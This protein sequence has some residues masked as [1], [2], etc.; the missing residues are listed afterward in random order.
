[1]IGHSRVYTHLVIA[2]VVAITATNAVVRTVRTTDRFSSLGELERIVP[3]R[4]RD[5]KFVSS[6]TCQACHPEHY[7]SWHKTFHRT[8]TQVASSQ[9]VSGDFRDVQ[10]EYHEKRFRLQQRGEE[11]WVIE[12]SEERRVFMTT[13][14]HHYQVYW[15]RSRDGDWL[16][17]FP[18]VY[19]LDDRRW[20]PRNDAFMMPPE[21]SRLPE[22]PRTWNSSCIQC[23]STHGQPGID[24]GPVFHGTVVAELGIACEACHGPAEEHVRVN[25]DPLRRYAKHMAGEPDSSIVH[26][27]QATSSLHR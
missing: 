20:V 17:N 14:S 12:G 1:M 2:C 6:D 24:P 21:I 4:S 13:G 9:T 26:P 7:A 10:L 27:A 5:E 19:L 25:R 23:H 15:L 8:M 16:E 11:F 3:H 18:F 22:K